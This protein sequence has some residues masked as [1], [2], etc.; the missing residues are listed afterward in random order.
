MDLRAIF[1]GILFALIW[2]SAFSSARIIVAAAPPLLTLSIRFFIAGIIGVCI[3]RFFGQTF[4]LTRRQWKATV[5]FGV[6]QNALYLGLNFLGMQTVEASLA[7][8]IASSMPLMVAFAGWVIFRERL[9]FLA[10]VGL[11]L[12]FL[13]VA[14]IMGLRITGGAD[15]YGLLLCVIGSMALTVA[16]LAVRG[17]SEGGNVMMVVGLQMI[18]GAASL[19]IVGSLTEKVYVSWSLPFILA[20]V[21]TTLVP[22]LA[23]TLIWF[24]LVNRIGTVKA[25]T[26]HFLNPFFGVVIAAFVLGEAMSLLDFIGVIVI[27]IGILAVQMSRQSNLTEV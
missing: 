24:K 5:I 10:G 17:A 9:S 11:F 8:I 27:T 15:N 6:F 16:T 23:A 14:M 12:G 4:F 13:G 7:S 1:M 25:A 26:F 2:S 3:A 20:F 22:G 21:Y 18:I 19:A